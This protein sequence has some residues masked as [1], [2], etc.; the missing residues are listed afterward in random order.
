MYFWM[1]G[2]PG[3]VGEAGEGA[4]AQ[5]AVILQRH[6][7]ELVQ[8]LNGDELHTGPLPFPHLHQHVGASGDDLGLGMGHTEGHGVSDVFCLIKRFHRIIPG[9][10]GQGVSH[11]FWYFILKLSYWRKHGRIGHSGR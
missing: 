6:A 1:R 4:D 3:D 2:V 8:A 9:G 10:R 5:G 11:S 7:L